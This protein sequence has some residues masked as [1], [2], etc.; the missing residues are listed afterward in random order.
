MTAKIAIGYTHM[1]GTVAVLLA[2]L[3]LQCTQASPGW[4]LCAFVWVCMEA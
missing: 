3:S 2:L 4:S 1:L